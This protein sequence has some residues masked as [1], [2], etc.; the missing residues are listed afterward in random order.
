[1]GDRCG[2]APRW[3]LERRNANERREQR[4]KGETKDFDSEQKRIILV[5]ICEKHSY[6]LWARTIIGR[7]M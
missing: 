6:Y 3:V 1:M 2:K 4:I 5:I 7:I